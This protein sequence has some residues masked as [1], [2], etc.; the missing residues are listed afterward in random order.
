MRALPFA[1]H[2]VAPE[3]AVNF[4]PTRAVVS[5]TKGMGWGIDAQDIRCDDGKCRAAR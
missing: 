3:D 1:T 4:T 2:P 5:A